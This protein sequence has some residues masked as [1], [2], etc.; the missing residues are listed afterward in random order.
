MSLLNVGTGV[1]STIK[2][3]AQQ[4]AEIVGYRGEISWD[5][6]KPDG[7]PKKLLDV[8]RLSELG[9]SAKIPLK[10]GLQSTYMDYLRSRE[11]GSIR[12]G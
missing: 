4:V 2:D 12:Q 10:K 7:T 6:S 8:K 5:V 11:E 3:I 1:D 9:W